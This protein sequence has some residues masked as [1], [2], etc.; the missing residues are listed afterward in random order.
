MAEK[1]PP[2]RKMHE[3]VV[4]PAM[5]NTTCSKRRRHP[6][7]AV[8]EIFTVV[9]AKI[10]VGYGNALYIR[11]QGDG[12]SWE[13]GKRLS[14]V[15]AS[16]WVWVTDQAKDKLVFKLLLNDEVWARGEDLVVEAGQKTE[17]APSF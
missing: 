10:D 12:L 5:H 16:T 3:P 2:A 4:E 8:A 15:D 6:G 11:G 1:I 13:K 17:L 9:Q 14:S 7:A